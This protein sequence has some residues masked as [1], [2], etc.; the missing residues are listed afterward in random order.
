M[1]PL[2]AE[3]YAVER[4]E[5]MDLTTI[6]VKVGYAVETTAG[7]KPTAFTW[8]KRCKAISGIELTTDKIDLTAL[9]DKIKQYA[10]GAADTGGDWSLTFG[11]S[12]DV[13]TELAEMRS[14]Y[15]TAKESGK[16]TWFDVWFPGLAKSF[17]II[18][19]PGTIPMPEVSVGSPA[20]IKINCT[21]N[22]YKGLDTAIEPKASGE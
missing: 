15:E 8:L 20:E 11:L 16:A 3:S 10:Q 22:E 5:I 6:G 4:M 17:F 7:T 13:V 2:T 1:W 9:E 19:E 18:A 21:I 14:A 12:D